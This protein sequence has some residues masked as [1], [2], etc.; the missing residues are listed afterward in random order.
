[1]RDDQQGVV[2]ADYIA[3]HFKGK[4][5][6][7]V[8]DKSQYGKGLADFARKR[9]KERGASVVIN[10]SIN[11]GDKDFSALISKMKQ[12]KVEVIYFGGYHT[13]AGLIV[14]QAHDQGLTA[15][16]EAGDALTSQEF[17]SIAG[18]AGAGTLMTFDA[19]PRKSPIAASVVATFRKGGYDPEGYTLYTYA[20]IQIFAH[21]ATQAKSTKLADL[22]NVMHSAQFETV[23]GPIAFDAKGDVTTPA[24]KVYAWKDGKYDYAN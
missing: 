7:V 20:A 18:S 8:D 1:V 9:L 4:A 19:D 12:A 16:L 10:E 24:Y 13:E 15:T 5:I 23:L 6:A 14:R 21:A 3:D 11:A 22:L 2:G 17:W